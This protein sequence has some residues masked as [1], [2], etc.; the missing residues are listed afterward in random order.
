MKT[1][2]LILQD[3]KPMKKKMIALEYQTKECSQNDEVLCDDEVFEE[4][5]EEELAL[6]F[7]RIIK[8]MMRRNQPKKSFPNKKVGPKTKVDM[9]KIQCHGCNHF[10]HYKNDCPKSNKRK[11]H[12]T[13]K[14]MIAAWDDLDEVPER[15]EQEANVCLMTNLESKEKCF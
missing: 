7:R 11:I 4:D 10:G 2:E 5:N 1:H 14:Y 3:Y 13:K 6:L 8:L 12:F 15:G 9:S